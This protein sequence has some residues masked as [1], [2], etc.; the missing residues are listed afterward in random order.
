[1][2]RGARRPYGPHPPRPG[3]GLPRLPVVRYPEFDPF[4]QAVVDDDIL[5][6]MHA[7]DSGYTRTRTTGRARQEMLP[8]K[9]DPF[10]FM[11]MGKRP[12]RG[13]GVGTGV[14]R[15]AHALPR[16]ARSR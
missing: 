11:T 13:H 2:G 3:A 8:F 5:V 1:M 16:A 9:L 12:D 7:S 4:W 15:G 10:R 6:S 14:P